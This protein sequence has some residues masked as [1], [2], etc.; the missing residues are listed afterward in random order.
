MVQHGISG[1]TWLLFFNLAWVLWLPR[2]ARQLVDLKSPSGLNPARRRFTVLHFSEEMA[3]TL[4]RENPADPAIPA[5][6]LWK[7]IRPAVDSSPH[8][9]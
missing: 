4:N 3:T 7:I 8:F 9:R 5:F 6:I 1:V 2:N